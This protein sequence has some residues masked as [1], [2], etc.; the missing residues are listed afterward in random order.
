MSFS[1]KSA[2]YSYAESDDG[3]NSA[4]PFKGIWIDELEL[5]STG[6]TAIIGPSGS[7]KTT[8]L[9]MLAGFLEPRL[10]ADG[11]IKLFGEDFGATGHSAGRVSFVFQ[12]PFL[13]GAASGLTNILQGHVAAQSQGLREISPRRLRKILAQLGL[14]DD[15]KKLIAKRAKSLSGGE[16]Q[17]VAIARAL[18]TEPDAILCDEPTSS[19]D[20]LN[21]KRALD[22][23]YQWSEDNQKPVIWVTHNMEQAARY[24]DHFVFVSQGRL[25]ESTDADTDF[26]SSF[27]DPRKLDDTDFSARLAVL[28]DISS[29]ISNASAPNEEDGTDIKEPALV[30]SRSRFTRW[31][32]G[33]LSTETGTF[34]KVDRDNAVRLAPSNEQRL[35]KSIHPSAPEPSHWLG[36]FFWRFFK[37]SQLPL[38]IIL[39][40]LLL[41]VFTALFLGQMADSYSQKRL[42]DPSVA[43]LVFEHVVGER[44]LSGAEEPE[45]LDVL[46]VLPEL[47]SE[48][49]SSVLSANPD[50]DP[51]RVMIFGRR[52]VPQSQLKF[53]SDEPGCNVWVPVE[54]VALNVDDPLVQQTQLAPQSVDFVGTAMMEQIDAFVALARDRR[55]ALELTGAAAIDQNLVRLLRERC[56]LAASEPLVAEWAAGTAG[57]RE[58]ITLEIVAAI[59]RPPP[60][61]PSSLELLVFEHDLENA[62]N[63][64]DGPG[65]RNYRIASAYFPIDAFEVAKSYIQ[66]KGYRIRDDSSAAVSTLLQVSQIAR[67]A[68]LFL[69]VLN[70]IGCLI[71]VAMV[72]NNI[73]ELNKRVLAIFVAHGFRFVD[74]MLVVLRHLALA[75]VQSWLLAGLVVAAIWI[76]YAHAIPPEFTEASSQRD[77]SFFT[78]LGIM[79]SAFAMT[80][81]LVIWL[82]WRRICK[83]LKLFLQD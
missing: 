71:V 46:T 68:P 78:T 13:L 4:A 76:I 44:N 16:A 8:L 9:S 21:A 29:R 58:P 24:A 62:D 72:I 51:D 23:L 61:Y 26:L 69:I 27:G 5:S 41:Q 19:L 73:L 75:V 42:E 63:L 74:M 33:A 43:R 12:S 59:S 66:Q 34:E 17:R 56:G 25:L 11:H 2:Y 82:W 50:A 28:R 40:V 79:L 20:D 36:R 53:M 64:Q 47:R 65:L 77:L 70:I 45:N 3:E 48:L 31:I 22:A 57:T 35:V 32:A 30:L 54:T 14:A 60:V 81:V 18:L 15:S 37:Y 83:N 67:I 80:S 6:I 39:S 38:A 49:T 7:G 55:D 52:S 1:I 10:R